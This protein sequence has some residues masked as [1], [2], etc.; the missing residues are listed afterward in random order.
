MNKIKDKLK[1]VVK[2]AMG[3]NVVVN[4]VTTD[5]KNYTSSLEEY[6]KLN[7]DLENDRNLLGKRHDKEAFGKA[8]S[9]MED[10]FN[11][12]NVGVYEHD[13]KSVPD[14][15]EYDGL[16][17]GTP[18]RTKPF[19]PCIKRI[20]QTTKLR[21][22][23]WYPSCVGNINARQ[24][25]VNYLV[26][27]GFKLEPEGTY[28]GLGIENVTFTCSTTNAYH[29]I[30]KTIAHDKDIILM[31][32]P[33][34]G[35]FA[36]IPE[37]TSAHVEVLDLA[38]EDDWYVNPDKLAKRIDELNDELK[39][40]YKDSNLDYQ[41]K[42]VAFLNI[43]PH[44]PIGKVMNEKNKEI[45]EGIA[46][47]CLEK[48]VFVIDDLIYRDLT[49]DTDNLALPIAM[50]PKYFNNTISLFGLSKAFGLASIR[51]GFVVAPFPIS[52][53]LAN[54]IA[55]SMDSIPVLQ[56]EAVAAGF[57]GT[58]KRYRAHKKYI[59]PIIREYQYRYNL[60]YALV[61]G[62]D[63]V[64]D[65]SLVGKIIRDVNKYTKNKEVTKELLKG[66]EGVHFKKGTKP[67]SGFFAVLDFTDLKGKKTH[68]FTINRDRDLLA[69][70]YNRGK[71]RF[72]MGSN[73][74]WPNK[75]EII[76]RVT[77]GL[78]KKAIIKNM[79]IVNKCVKELK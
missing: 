32:G 20:K 25:I 37:L 68:D 59:K 9:H 28:E 48:K 30:L 61:E 63:N 1:V 56:V 18:M 66:L 51:A 7:P 78:D 11:F 8:I 77:F 70:L 14:M 74:C 79:M 35:I 41:P 29:L 52:R 75:D 15:S 22:L 16:H 76:A 47:V 24:D 44:N 53:A 72:I 4:H 57:N 40:K 46:E 64:E 62:I 73:M 12:F 69:L 17:S 3:L 23:Y 33:N 55:H 49:F 31:T 6:I 54:E 10:N 58:D 13:D 60:M 38:E 5:S 43:N 42:V 27:E 50:N 34:Y 71:V 21:N 45:L 67:D 19:Y 2:K 39:E 36:I 65:K 26:R